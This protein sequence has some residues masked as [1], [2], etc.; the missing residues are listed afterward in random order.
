MAKTN[1]VQGTLTSPHSTPIVF[2][3]DQDSIR[4]AAVEL[5]VNARDATH[6]GY[7]T[8]YLRRGLVLGKITATGKYIDYD[9]DGTDDGRR[10]AV[11][12]LN[13]DV[14]LLD[15]FGSAVTGPVMAS[16]IVQGYI[17]A[18]NLLGIDANGKADLRTAGFILSEDF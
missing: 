6:T 3:V 11:C 5:N 18:T 2:I 12:I 7:R 16:V 17:D 9:D 13:E 1:H 8:T 15:E 10:T 14:D 4:I